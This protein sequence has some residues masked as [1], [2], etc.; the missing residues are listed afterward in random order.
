M[1]RSSG[2]I[3]TAPVALLTLMVTA[4]SAPSVSWVSSPEYEAVCHPDAR[5][6]EWDPKRSG[7]WNRPF[8]IHRRIELTRHG[9]IKMRNI[10]LCRTIP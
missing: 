4:A 7:E 6:E 5:N 10:V 2:R 3:L 1:T 9:A 8:D